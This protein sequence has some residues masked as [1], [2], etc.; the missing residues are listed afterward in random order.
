MSI[1]TNIDEL[2]IASILINI[3]K[4]D[5]KNTIYL[6]DFNSFIDRFELRAINF[7]KTFIQGLLVID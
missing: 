4:S 6:T 7:L 3:D 1:L 5:R 2:S